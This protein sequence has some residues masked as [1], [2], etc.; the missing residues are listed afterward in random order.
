MSAR[1]CLVHL[2]NSNNYIVL[3]KTYSFEEGTISSHIFLIF[4]IANHS[5]RISDHI[6]IDIEMI[7]YK[8][9]CKHYTYKQR[10]PSLG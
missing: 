1:P 3:F 4:L 9:H 6:I 10:D 8:I 5:L 2:H 7:S